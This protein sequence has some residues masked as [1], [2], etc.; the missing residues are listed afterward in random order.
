MKRSKINLSHEVLL[1]ADMGQLIPVA[2]V[3]VLPGDT[4]RH[5]TS[6]LIRFV[7]QAKP[8][9]HPV[10]ARIHHFYVPYRTVWSGWEDFI[11]GVSATAPPQGTGAAH[12]EGSLLDYMNY[13]DDTSANYNLLNVRA[14]NKI[15]NEYF[16][17]QD[18]ISEVSE[19]ST[20]VQN[21]SWAKDYFTAARS[22]PQQGSAVSLPL[23]TTADVRFAGINGE[24]IGVKGSSGSTNYAA[25]TNGTSGDNIALDTG[26]NPTNSLYADLTNATAATINE[27]REAFALQKYAE[28]RNIYGDN[29]VD[30]L[31]YLGIKPSDG[32]LQRAEMLAAGNAPV[33]FSEVLDTG[34]SAAGVGEQAGHG[35]AAIRSNRYQRFFEEHGVVI[36]LLS[37]RPKS[38]Y[39]QAQPRDWTKQTK[40]DYYQQ[41]LA[42]IGD[43]EIL[44]R[45]IYAAHTTPAGTFGYSPRYDEYRGCPSYVAGEMRN[46]T[47]YDTHFGR[48]FSSDPALNQ[49]FVECNP[50][51][52]V[53]NDQVEDSMWIYVKNSIGARRP[54]QQRAG[55]A[56]V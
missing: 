6:A 16:R 28:A 31:R 21:I 13:Y 26:S 10:Q 48:I 42:N 52:R 35:I 19:D 12:S 7:S 39:T 30:Y 27:L 9:M 38:I 25:D 24:D 54:I 1:S 36:S 37:V 29:Y 17:D 33:N 50:T 49:T 40:E 32:R 23:G 46:S 18:L 55:Y 51:K 47:N 11:T 14:Y 53:F 22:S 2:T 43:Q 45:E 44:N 8:V 3:P 5:R 34:S 4:F 15:Y 56:G 41:E 20:S